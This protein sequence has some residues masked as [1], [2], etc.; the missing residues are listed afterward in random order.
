MPTLPHVI[1]SARDVEAH[2]LAA[3]GSA[4][5]IELQSVS[6]QLKVLVDQLKR[7][8]QLHEGRTLYCVRVIKWFAY[9]HLLGC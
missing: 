6:S 3:N 7:V 2:R 5:A 1:S 4:H 8:E 9:V